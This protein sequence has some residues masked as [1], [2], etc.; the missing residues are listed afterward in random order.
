MLVEAQKIYGHVRSEAI[1]RFKVWRE[2]ATEVRGWVII[3][4]AVSQR[5]RKG[6]GS[7]ESTEEEAWVRGR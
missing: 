5:T 1:V 2:E 4:C 6:I 7:V 3:L